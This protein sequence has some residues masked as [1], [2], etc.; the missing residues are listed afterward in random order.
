MGGALGQLGRGEAPGPVDLSREHGHLWVEP[1]QVLDVPRVREWLPFLC[2]QPERTFL[3]DPYHG[4]G[5]FPHRGQ[6]ILSFARLD[7]SEN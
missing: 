1:T 5:T 2:R 4:E 7:A 6:L 3:R